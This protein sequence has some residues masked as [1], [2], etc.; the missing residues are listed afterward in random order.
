[1][2]TYRPCI[3]IGVPVLPLHASYGPEP[4][5]E[6]E[7]AEH[8]DVQYLN[9]LYLDAGIQLQNLFRKLLDVD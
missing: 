4:P 5:E 6:Y 9:I 3:I 8:S 7:S 1:M 2:N